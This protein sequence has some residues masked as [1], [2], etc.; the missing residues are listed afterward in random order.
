MPAA[1]AGSSLNIPTWFYGH[2]PT[3]IFAIAIAKYFTDALGEDTVSAPL[4]GRVR[5]LA[6]CGRDRAGDLSGRD[7]ELL[8]SGRNG[9]PM[10]LVG[11]DYWTRRYP[12]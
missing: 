11:L 1:E 4:P 2:E 10:V 7:R 12:A 9:G 5:V 3:N 6:R 8:R